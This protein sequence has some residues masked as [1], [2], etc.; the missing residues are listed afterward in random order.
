M[1]NMATDRIYGRHPV[2]EALKANA[3]IRRIL[4]VQGQ[5][6]GGIIAE[7]IKLAAERSVPI[8]RLQRAALDRMV[9]AEANHQGVAAE[10]PPYRYHSV[11]S[12]LARAKEKGELP[13]LLVLD[14]I[15]DVHNFGA[16]LRT[17]E[18]AGV[19]GVLIPERR[20]VEVTPTVYKSSAGAVHYIPIAQVTNLTVTI[21]QLQQQNIW[22]AGLDMDGTQLH[23]KAN[24]GGALGIVVG[25]EGKGLS[26][27]V[28]ES[29]DF[30]I[31]LPMHGQIHSLNA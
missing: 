1:N 22:F 25:A 15:Q 2:L 13:F 12:I 31:R 20:A 16:L 3:R 26:R 6:E 10:L 29:C 14:G 24:L 18:A 28:A 4:L 7:I 27:L 5:Q 17:A 8:E 21:K 19:H 9:E 30:L 11:E 23:H